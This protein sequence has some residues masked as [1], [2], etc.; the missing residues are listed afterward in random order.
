MTSNLVVNLALS[1]SLNQLWSALNSQQFILH[2]PIFG[3]LKFPGNALSFNEFMLGIAKF[4]LFDTAERIDKYIF[5]LP[6]T[7]AFN[8]GFEL[9]K[10]N[11]T[12]L[13]SN[14]SMVVW[15]FALHLSCSFL[16]ACCYFLACN[17]YKPALTKS[18]CANYL[19][20][21]GFIRLFIETFFEL[22]LSAFVNIQT[23]DWETSYRGVKYS[24]VLTLI[25]LILIGLLTPC[26]N[27]LY[28]RN[29]SILT[30]DRFKNRYGAGLEEVNLTKKESPRSILAFPLFFFSRRIL[31][32]VSAVFLDDFLWAQIAI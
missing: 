8:E 1:G 21:N 20:W 13:V 12:L 29:F 3:N 2:F 26:L 14:I 16:Y 28:C 10:Y 27:F 15:M 9:C 32:A 11:S 24:N 19:F 17:K 5:T 4:D 7:D 31:F 25:S 23:A 6:E 18:K 30:E 22:A